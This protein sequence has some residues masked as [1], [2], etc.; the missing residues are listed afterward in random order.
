MGFNF[1]NQ[2]D[3]TGTNT[4]CVLTKIDL[5]E[6]HKI[7]NIKS[8]LQNKN[9][10]TTLN[11][12]IGL[13]NRTNEELLA[14]ENLFFGLRKEKDFFR[15]MT[16]LRSLDLNEHFGYDCLVEKIKKPIYEIISTS[17][18]KIYEET[19]KK[20]AECQV[21]I[22]KFGTDYILS[23]NTESSKVSYLSTL[24]SQFSDEIDC[25]FSGKITKS[26]KNDNLTNSSM[27]KMYYEF[28]EDY[29][30]NCNLPS[31]SLKNEEIIHIIKINEGDSISGFPEAEVIHSVLE[32]EIEKI[33]KKV[34]EYV[35]EIIDLLLSS[36]K[37]SIDV[38][39][40]RYPPLIERIEEIINAF[41]E[42]VKKFS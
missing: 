26:N 3:K 34:K 21:E 5:A 31:N 19:K 9:E 24:L 7:D 12:F 6:K 17:I 13:K 18:P 20:I 8:L 36:V 2:I 41:L 30:N 1:A 16:Q 35:D 4:F 10:N 40:C 14:N 28:L 22:Q 38:Q 11:G 42:T 27:K 37:H 25:I 32:N 29:K 15:S 23:G 39:F 33:R